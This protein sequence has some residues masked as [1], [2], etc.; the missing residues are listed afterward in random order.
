LKDE[1]LQIK[2]AGERSFMVCER[3]TIVSVPLGVAA[4]SFVGCFATDEHNPDVAAIFDVDKENMLKLFPSFSIVDLSFELEG[5]AATM[6]G[7]S[8]DGM[9]G[10]TTLK[11]MKSP[12][13]NFSLDEPVP[14]VAEINEAERVIVIAEKEEN[15][16]RALLSKG[17]R[18]YEDRVGDLTD[19]DFLKRELYDMEQRYKTVARRLSRR[20]LRMEKNQITLQDGQLRSEKVATKE[21]E[22]LEYEDER[23][24]EISSKVEKIKRFYESCGQQVPY[25]NKKAEYVPTD[26]E[27]AFSEELGK[28]WKTALE[29]SKNEFNEALG[30]QVTTTSVPVKKVGGDD[31]DPDDA[32]I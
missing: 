12:T 25:E 6:P 24:Q 5:K 14:D 15:D 23:R 10:P 31:E 11:L 21:K 29:T 9:A 30:Q 18:D 27:K 4:Y 1:D 32:V 8:H 26:Q 2:V 16:R 17:Q 7:Y 19:V 28:K 22:L 20:N 13:K 3:F